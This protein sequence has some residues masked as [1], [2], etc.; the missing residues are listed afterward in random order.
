MLTAEQLKTL[1]SVHREVY[2][3]FTYVPD[4]V[5]WKTPEYW[6]SVQ[7]IILMEQEDKYS[8]DCD[9][10]ALAVRYHLRKHNIPNQ[11]LLCWV[12]AAAGYHLEVYSHGYISE[13]NHPFVMT[14]DDLNQE[15]IMLS[16]FEKGEPWHYVKPFTA[17][18]TWPHLRG[19]L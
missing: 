19:T 14:L 4:S 3:S 11:L 2:N 12:H 7:D 8:G 17:I 5:K 6:A 15:N 9:D 13:C 10:F 18:T 1:E 16:G